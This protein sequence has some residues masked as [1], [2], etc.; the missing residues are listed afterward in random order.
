MSFSRFILFSAVIAIFLLGIY[1]TVG[2][3][4][5]PNK[6]PM[7]LPVVEIIPQDE[8]SAT[9]EINKRIVAELET[10]YPAGVRPMRRDVHAK[11]HGCVK[12]NFEIQNQNLPPELR[13]G[14]FAHNQ[15][16]PAWIRFSNSSGSIQ[17][18]SDMSARGMAIKLMNVPGAKILSDEKN[19]QTQDFVLIN[20]PVF[21]MDTA[22]NFASLTRPDKA[23]TFYFFLTHPCLVT[24]LVT[25]ILA[26]VS[27]PLFIR[28]WSSTPYRLGPAAVKYTVIP[29]R[30][31]NLQK[32]NRK[33]KDFLK[34]AMVATLQSS[35]ACFRFMVQLQK[36][37]QTM[38]IENPTVN[39]SEKHSPFIPVATIRIFPQ[40][41]DTPQQMEFCENTT[42]TPWHALPEHRPLGGINRVRKVVYEAIS[43][44][45][46]KANKAPQ[47]EPQ[48]VN[49]PGTKP[50][51]ALH[52]DKFQN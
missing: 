5:N 31:D 20:L 4:Q 49:L 44:L 39:W 18:D 29:C 38:P 35:E 45:R 16:Y 22:S 7:Y 34:E 10:Q 15:T 50:G 40:T 26:K 24:T 17:P 33:H 8:T 1:L 25:H 2:S 12:A 37:N 51:Q 36:D 43:S 14:V 6:T 32:V 23:F 41:F 19:A 21:F 47:I 28:Y 27:N 3:K 11:Q 52:S 9:T 13:V 30:I 48:P 42:F 46:H